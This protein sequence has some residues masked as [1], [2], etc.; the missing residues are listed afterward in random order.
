MLGVLGSSA[1][2]ALVRS[3]RM[4]KGQVPSR[5]A[6][7]WLQFPRERTGIP[8]AIST[9]GC[10]WLPWIGGRVSRRLRR[11]TSAEQPAAAALQLRRTRPG[12]SGD[13][14]PARGASAADAHRSRG[15]GQDPPGAGRGSRG[16][17]SYEDGAWLVELAPL[18]DPELVPQA[19][20]SVLGVREAPG[21]PL[22]ETLADHLGS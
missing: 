15:L 14:G 3:A 17:G 9:E 2:R 19:L 8:G 13:R 18:S 4:R 12:S 6:L 10:R 11:R 7:L 1:R 16:G 21:S 20:A 5:M 22:I